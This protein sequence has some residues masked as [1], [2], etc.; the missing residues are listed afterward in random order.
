MLVQHV[1]GLSDADLITNNDI[2]LTNYQQLKLDNA[3]AQRL[4]GRPV[5][6]IIGE[7]G[8]YGRSFITS[9]D[10]LDPRPDSETLIEAVLKNIVN[11]GKPYRIL[12]LGV[13]SGCLVLTLLAELPN[14]TALATDI[15]QKALAVARRNAEKLDIAERIDFIESNWFN[16]VNGT[17]DIIVSNPPYIESRDIEN[18]AV[19]VRE[20]DPLLALDGG[21]EGLDPYKVI[22]PQ[23]RD[24]LN[25]GGITAL[26]HGTGQSERISA[27]ARDCG[28][29]GGQTCHDYAGHDRVFLFL[30]K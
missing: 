14:A 15:S 8:F 2:L 17:F 23:I 16:C 21:E 18:L 27:I 10:V 30:H 28:I 25:V 6:K 9:D 20:Y 12:E 29:V 24:Y 19:N 11:K 1:T 13:G 4:K 7:K 22:L 3:I 5:S 26:E